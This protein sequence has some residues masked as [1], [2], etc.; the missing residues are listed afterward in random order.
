MPCRPDCRVHIELEDHVY[1]LFDR[2]GMPRAH[3]RDIKD[4]PH[5]FHIWCTL[6]CEMMTLMCHVVSAMMLI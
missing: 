4:D 5:L 3:V 6:P 2:E 1:A